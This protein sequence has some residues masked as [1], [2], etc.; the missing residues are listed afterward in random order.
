MTATATG[1]YHATWFPLA[2]SAEVKP[3]EVIGRDALGTRLA[4]YRDAGGTVVVQAAYC[5]HL[6]ADLSA[7]EVVGGQIRCAFHHWSF[8]RGGTCVRIPAGDKIPPAARIF[9]Y[10]SAEK[11]GLIWAFN[12]EAPAFDVPAI[13]G[14]SETE[15]VYEARERGFRSNDVWVAVSNGVDFQHLRTLHG[16][17]NA[18]EPRDLIAGDHSLEYVTGND[19]YGQHGLIT[20]TNTFAQHLRV[21]PADSYMLFSGCAVDHGRTRGFY[22]VGVRRD[23]PS[24][25]AGPAV[26]ARLKEVRDFADR[27]WA[28]DAR[29]LA[30]IHFRKGTLVASDRHLARFLKYVEDFPR[31]GET[32]PLALAAAR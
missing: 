27:L 23:G 8:D 17:P 10:P 2:L 29:I 9:T 22:V 19:R 13:P 1:G 32:A 21:G 11:W 26:A 20:G 15:I 30:G 3:G 28:D 16:L 6:G 14:A 12:G 4:V 18:V 31:F 25:G 7:G 5:P 24:A